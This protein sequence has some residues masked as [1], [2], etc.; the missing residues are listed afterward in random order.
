[1]Q[2]KSFKFFL[3]ATCLLGGI[4]LLPQGIFAQTID[5][6]L[7]FAEGTGLTN[8]DPRVV[9]AN[10]I[11]VVLGFLGIIAVI[12]VLYAGFVMMTSEGNEEKVNKSK[13]VLKAAV[14]GLIIILSAFGIVSFILGVL[15]SDSSGTSSVDTQR[16]STPGWGS[17]SGVLG[18]GIVESV[19]PEPFSDD[20]SMNTMIIATF[21]EDIAIS[22]VI[23]QE[24]NVGLGC[25]SADI[26]KITN[27]IRI[28][29][30]GDSCIEDD[31]YIDNVEISNFVSALA[32]TPDNKTFVFVPDEY[33][34]TLGQ[35]VTYEVY[36][37][38]GIDGIIKADNTAAF[39]GAEVGGFHWEFDT[40]GKV[41]LTS[42]QVRS[43]FPPQDNYN[44]QIVSVD[45]A[46]NSVAATA[47][48]RVNDIPNVKQVAGSGI[49]AFGAGNNDVGSLNGEY[50]CSK[51]GY[52]SVS[53]DGNKNSTIGVS[54]S[55]DEVWYLS[56][57]LDVYNAVNS[58]I[59]ASGCSHYESN[60][61]NEGR[62][63]NGTAKGLVNGSETILDLLL[64][65]DSGADEM[66]EI[67]C[68]LAIESDSFVAGQSWDIIVEAE[69]AADSLVVGNKTYV[70]VAVGGRHSSLPFIEVGLNNITTATNIKNALDDNSSVS[71][72]SSGSVI[73][74]AAKT[75]GAEGNDIELS[76]SN[77]EAIVINAMAGGVDAQTRIERNGSPED[78]PKNVTI[79]I[80]FNEAVNPMMVVGKSDDV[81]DF[82][83]V[84]NTTPEPDEIVD[85]KFEISNLYKTI[86]FITDELCGVNG[87]GEEIYCLPGDA[88]L[89]VELVAASL[90]DC[91]SLGGEG[92]CATK[93]PFIACGGTA[94]TCYSEVAIMDPSGY[95]CNE[96]N[97]CQGQNE[98]SICNTVEQKCETPISMNRS[99]AKLPLNGITDVALNSLDGNRDYNAEGQNSFYDLNENSSVGGDNF[100]WSFYTT[101]ELDLEAPV[102]TAQSVN[103][104]DIMSNALGGV[105]NIMNRDLRDGYVFTVSNQGEV[106]YQGNPSAVADEVN[107]TSSNDWSIYGVQTRSV[108]HISWLKVDLGEEHEIT[109]FAVSGY[110]GGNHKPGGNWSLQGSSDGDLWDVLSTASYDKWKPF[111]YVGADNSGTYP[112][113]ESQIIK[114][115]NPAS[116]RYYRVYS[117][118]FG[119]SGTNDYMLVMNL[120]LW[121]GDFLDAPIELKFSKVMQSSSI[122]TGQKKQVSGADVVIQRFMNL[123]NLSGQSVGYWASNEAVD[124]DSPQD[125]FVDKTYA[126]INHTKFNTANN[127]RGQ[128]G[129]GLRD[130]YQNCFKPCQGPES[131]CGE[132][133]EYEPSWCSGEAK[134]S[135]ECN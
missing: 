110:P 96:D 87:C 122:S 119:S 35:R 64:A 74:V 22:S 131:V 79:Q 51:D 114:V 121:E 91:N 103:H 128:V 78:Q 26:G 72:E 100:K 134:A 55:C 38:G 39:T 116:Y 104:G 28:Y 63:P 123:E 68:G 71:V 105:R 53:L 46:E 133:L 18:A 13:D 94:N 107:R 118:T 102:I 36:F 32:Q 59:F 45:G 108:D 93:S 20:I 43:V 89:K 120:G 40:N 8:T 19:Y 10:I 65:G 70:F 24:V 23:C 49:A 67:G 90:E 41:D 50:T 115:N 27:N 97:D 88:N 47:S 31:C 77:N 76:T 33:L 109:H 30:K 127:V 126:Y 16:G 80:N 111:S 2:F 82:I 17:G 83:R 81:K 135:A 48:I 86:E 52:F 1:M 98:Y 117:D 44:D 132:L 58:G 29:K 7:E 9:A 69:K 125:G 56:E 11:R 66:V 6:G 124:I 92:Y 15:T 112:F 129:S 95:V 14:I 130:I 60:G 37:K 106:G 57:Y 73:N 84:V 75:P 54:Q 34:G 42:P 12:L 113:D 4:F 21:R 61:R 3:I 85:G 99:V 5:T 62:Y 101:P 25:T